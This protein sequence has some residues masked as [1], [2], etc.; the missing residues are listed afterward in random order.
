[1][2]S[3]TWLPS[4]ANSKTAAA[5]PES[6]KKHHDNTRAMEM[7]ASKPNMDVSCLVSLNLDSISLFLCVPPRLCRHSPVGYSPV[8]WP[9]DVHQLV[10][11]G[12]ILGSS[13]FGHISLEV[14]FLTKVRR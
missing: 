8:L 12:S 2:A 3:A 11:A 13:R 10:D 5:W 6:T 14:N 1:M 4:R 9:P 7:S